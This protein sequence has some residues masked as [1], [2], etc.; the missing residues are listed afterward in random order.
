MRK[1]A[2]TVAVLAALAVL[3][4]CAPAA[5]GSSASNP[6]PAAGGVP[7]LSEGET[8]YVRVDHALADL[9]LAPRDL[10]PS[11]WVPSGYDSE[12]G[13]LTGQFALAADRVP[14]GW[15]FRLHMVRVERSSERGSGA[16]DDSRAVYAMWAVYEVTAPAE[17][18]PGPYRF[19][20]TLRARGA[21]E[22]PVTVNV[23]LVG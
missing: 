20:G 22:A 6:Y 15:T 2:L 23:E 12:V 19:R 1:T 17:A 9:D 8:I 3:S 10:Q 5:L 18:I 7:Q 13:D 16:S 4:S 11:L 21:G 14:E